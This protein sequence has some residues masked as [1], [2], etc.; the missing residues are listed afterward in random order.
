MV[1]VCLVVSSDTS[2]VAQ[3]VTLHGLLTTAG[4]TVTYR[5]STL[6]LPTSG[7]DVVVITESGA[8]GSAANGDVPTSSLPVV[9]METNWNTTRMASVAATSAG[10][11]TQLNII[12]T[13]HPIVAGVPDPV[14]H[15]SPGF[16]AYGTATA[17]LASGVVNVAE[18]QGTAGHVVL[19]A[20]DT[21]ATLT[22]GTAPA[23]RVEF[24]IG[25]GGTSVSRWTTDANT[26]FVQAVEWAAGVG[27][28]SGGSAAGTF[29]FTGAASGSRD[30][31]GS[32]TGTY[33]FTGSA[34]GSDGTKTLPGQVDGVEP[35]AACGFVGPCVDSN[36]TMYRVTEEYLGAGGAG[37]GNHPMMMKSA[38]GGQTWTRVDAANGPGYGVAGSYND[39]ESAWLAHD[40]TN[41]VLWLTYMKGQSRWWGIAFRTSDHPT[42]PDTWDTSTFA[43]SSGQDSFGTTAS[44]SGISSVVLSDGTVR[45]FIRGTPQGGFQSFLHRTRSGGAW[46]TASSYITDGLNM[47][48]PSAVVA[49]SDT[50]YLFYKDHTNGQIRYRTIS[51]TG[52]VGASARVDS[53]GA[54]TTASYENNVVA[55][56][57]YDD[58]G[59][60]VVVVGFVNSSNVLRTVEIRGGVVGAEQQVSTDTVTVNPL[61][62]VGS[63]TDN[64]GPAAA[65]AV[66]G[67]TVYAFWGDNTSG[68]LYYAT[69]ANGGAWSA[70]TLLADT[71]TSKAVHWLHARAFTYAGG[72]YIGY[73]YDIGPHA[74]DGSDIKYNEL[75]VAPPIPSGSATGSFDFTGSAGGVR[76]SLGSAT[77]A[78]SWAGAASGTST[79]DGAASGGFAFSGS[80]TGSN[81]TTL[82]QGSASGTYSFAG[83]A[84]GSRLSLGS[85]SGGYAFTGSAGGSVPTPGGQASGTYVFT[86]SAAGGRKKVFIPP[87]ARE[88]ILGDPLFSRYGVSVGVTIIKKGGVF[89]EQPYPWLGELAG[90]TDGVD[91]FLGGRVYEVTDAVAADL[92]ASGYTAS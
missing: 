17:N 60:P 80:A 42:N 92:A 51:S 46:D 21:G 85:T 20:A 27:G 79:K 4:H 11:N 39:L 71:G 90:L 84:A 7:F 56:V 1:A 88:A 53:G 13:T 29:D 49:N 33:D 68:D 18:A 81:T 43:T 70:R 78:V 86:G 55:P 8:S 82:G 83:G 74:D 40:P 91:Y 36:G 16:N 73:T 37:F 28:A 66:V 62:S 6:N 2:P 19:A 64:Q 57:Y 23:R 77:G 47:T 59:T 58:A 25:I 72:N 75:T 45:A 10:S 26:V 3:D 32:A 50:T 14:T 30:S 67:T 54:G 44:E 12:D 35:E 5:L 61:N 65:L 87:T 76:D 69:R 24:G 9:H 15:G 31:A 34:A 48:R 63:S 89:V 41:K 38:D 52:T 22:T